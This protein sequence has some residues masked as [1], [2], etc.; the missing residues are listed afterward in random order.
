MAA[1]FLY[2]GKNEARNGL[3]SVVSRNYAIAEKPAFAAPR[4]LR[5]A[6]DE[7]P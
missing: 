2:R 7:R 3:K 4:L 6:Q 1:L 5:Q